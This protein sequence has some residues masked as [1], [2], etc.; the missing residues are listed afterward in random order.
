MTGVELRCDDCQ[1]PYAR[2]FADNDV[3]NLV[4]GGPAA[5]DDPGGML[6]PR[7]FTIRAAIVYESPKWHLD[8]N[9]HTPTESHHQPGRDGTPTCALDGEYVDVIPCGGRCHPGCQTTPVPPATTGGTDE[10]ER[11]AKWFHGLYTNGG[12]CIGHHDTREPAM[13]EHWA[14]AV[15]A[16]DWLRERD[17]ARAAA[18]RADIA[19]DIKARIAAEPTLMHVVDW[20]D[21]METAARIALGGTE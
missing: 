17:L 15:L 7:C 1:Q 21:G 18:L 20:V 6:C 4:I 10:A 9:E 2:W 19:R 11:L 13:C 8:L 5:T 16:S 14:A 12:G 3:W